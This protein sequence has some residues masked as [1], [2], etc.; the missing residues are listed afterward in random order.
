MNAPGGGANSVVVTPLAERLPGAGR[1]RPSILLSSF[2]CAPGRGS[3]PGLG[4]AVVQAARQLGDVTVITAAANRPVIERERPPAG[5]NWVY[6]ELPRPLQWMAGCGGWHYAYYVFW[7]LAAFAAARHLCRR[8]S[9]DLVHHV[10]YTAS[11]TLTLMGYLGLPFIFNGGGREAT[12]V[13]FLRAMSRRQA[14][15]EVLR[16]ALLVAWFHLAAAPFVARRARV[17]VTSSPPESWGRYGPRVIRMPMGA[18]GARDLQR[19]LAY[20]GGTDARFRVLLAGV[21]VGLKGFR[22]ALEAFARLR[23]SV[24]DAELWIAGDGPERGFLERRSTE[25]E[26]STA[27]RFL[28]WVPREHMPG[29]IDSCDVLVHPSLHEQLGYVLLEAMAAG[30]P[31][32]CLARGGPEVMPGVVAVPAFSPDQVVQ[33]LAEVLTRLARD[34]TERARIGMEGRKAVREAYSTEALVH[35]LDGL[36]R[37]AVSFCGGVDAVA[38]N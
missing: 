12:P 7:Q 23:Q 37:R 11:W 35:R 22:L 20:R 1:F 26:L 36:Y 29:V 9:F 6:V 17:I 28:G 10:T 3:E 38:C 2:A 14:A 27:V 30:R 4:W 15:F 16:G 18:L 19:P 25:L 32:L 21:L 34:P 33:D 13:R 8:N 31:A 24:S 5:V